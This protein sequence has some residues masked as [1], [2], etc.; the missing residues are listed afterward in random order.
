VTFEF[1]E[2]V[3][4]LVESILFRGKLEGGGGCFVNLAD[5]PASYG[6]VCLLTPTELSALR[7]RAFTEQQPRLPETPAQPP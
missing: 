4:E 3:A 6:R 1:A 2:V 7:I 5:S